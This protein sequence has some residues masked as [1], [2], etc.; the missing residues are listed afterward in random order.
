[1]DE[2]SAA[3]AAVMPTPSPLKRGKSSL[4]SSL[5]SPEAL[6]PDTD[7]EGEAPEQEEEQLSDQEKK[8]RVSV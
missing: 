2:E 4:E 3:L 7:D 1:V 6:D 8:V 5:I